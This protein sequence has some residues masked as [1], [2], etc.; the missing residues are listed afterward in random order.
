M[1]RHNNRN[2]HEQWNKKWNTLTEAEQRRWRRRG[3][4]MFV[5]LMIAFGLIVSLIFLGMGGLA[6]LF[7]RWMDGETHVAVFVWIGG[8]LSFLMFPAVAIFLAFQAYR[9]IAKPLSE[10]IN[11]AESVSQ[12]DLSVRVSTTHKGQFDGLTKAF[13][14]MV[15][16]LELADQRRRNLTADVAHELR[17]PLHIIQGN[18]EGILD[19]V[20]E[21]TAE[22]IEAT[23]DETRILARLVE[24]LRVLSLAEAGQLQLTKETVDVAELLA[25]VVT[26]FSGQAA[27][28]EV[29]LT[30]EAPAGLSVSADY[31]RLTQVINNLV[32]NSLRH[33]P[34][35]GK[36]QLVA[37]NLNGHIE[38]SVSDTGEGI[39]AEQLPYIFDRFWRGDQSRQHSGSTGLGLAI[40][41]QLILAH[42]GEI[43]VASKAGV[44][45]VFTIA[46]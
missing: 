18:L 43:R 25:D 44:G 29:L 38:L 32:S 22:H 6:L 19:E 37:S 5:R 7:T 12:G 23:L 4:R 20:Y 39:P 28:A 40:A 24:D 46:I 15:S 13:N 17:T 34:A 33:T 9:N 16:E 14:H 30:H 42:N 26:S 2:H 8:L 21:P 11:A 1:N 35:G 31:D 10:V 36:I 41:R 27:V 3:V 45:T